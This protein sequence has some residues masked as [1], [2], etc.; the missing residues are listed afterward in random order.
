MTPEAAIPRLLMDRMAAL[1]GHSPAIPVAYP[2]IA[3]SPSVGQEYIELR[4]LPNETT[5]PSVGSDSRFYRGLFQATVCFPEGEIGLRPAYDLAGEIV[6]HYKKGTK[7][8]GFGVRV[9]IY[10]TPWPAAHLVE[11]GWLRVPV[12]IPYECFRR[13]A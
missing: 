2:G 3:F 11:G 5:S 9:E 7:L 13:A 10:R 12:T 4:H 1:P 6:D 8:D